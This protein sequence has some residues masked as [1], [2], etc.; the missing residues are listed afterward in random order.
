M[1]LSPLEGRNC[2]C[3]PDH[4]RND[5]KSGAITPLEKRA[6]YKTMKYIADKAGAAI[7]MIP[8][9]YPNKWDVGDALT[10]GNERYIAGDDLV[11]FIEQYAVQKPPTNGSPPDITADDSNQKKEELTDAGDALRLFRLHGQDIRFM[12]DADAYVLWTGSRWE[13]Q[14]HQTKVMRYMPSLPVDI[15][16]EIRRLLPHGPESEVQEKIWEAYE[17][18]ARKVQSF[19]TMRSVIS[20]LKSDERAEI[21]QHDLDSNPW[22]LNCNNGTLNMDTRRFH[23]H[24]RKDFITKRISVDFN[25][26]AKCPLWLKTV[27]LFLPDAELQEYFQRAIGYS[28]TGDMRERCFFIAHG[29]GKNGKSTLINTPRAILNEYAAQ[30]DKGVFFERKFESDISNGLA[31]LRGCRFVSASETKEGDE[32]AL[33]LIKQITGGDPITARFLH[34]EFFEFQPVMKIWLATNHRPRITETNRAIW[35]RVHL[36]PF[37]VTISD[38]DA[39]DSIKD[40]LAQEASGILNWMLEGYIKWR[41][42]GLRPPPIV[43]DAIRAY[44]SIEDPMQGFINECCEYAPGGKS[45]VRPLHQSYKNWCWDNNKE[46]ISEKAFSMRLKEDFG[47]EKKKSPKQ[48]TYEFHGI[49]MKGLP[50]QQIITSPHEPEFWESS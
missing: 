24:Q 9:D 27:N 10:P 45:Q 42:I 50:V 34:Q 16:E 21:S 39:D 32:L 36:I 40:K 23:K 15:R 37:L 1:D 22:L 6:G 4:D 46:P 14:A 19:A 5:D 17:K 18:H 11:A 43:Q 48:R 47:L 28:M 35:D 13:I 41:E 49:R 30:A 7:I 31:R 8:E 33:A 38:E 29:K 26:N 2:I 20:I 12:P 3:W 25:R 44:R